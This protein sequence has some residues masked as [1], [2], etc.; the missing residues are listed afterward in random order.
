MAKKLEPSWLDRPSVLWENGNWMKIIPRSTMSREEMA[1][2]LARLA[3]LGG[4]GL[5]ILLR[6]FTVIGLSMLLLVMSSQILQRRK[7][8]ATLTGA[9][10]VRRSKSKRPTSTTGPHQQVAQEEAQVVQQVAQG[11]ATPLGQQKVEP[12]AHQVFTNTAWS[13]FFGVNQENRGA[14][15]G[16]YD[17]M[18]KGAQAHYYEGTGGLDLSQ[19]DS[20]TGLYS[21]IQGN[22][23]YPFPRAEPSSSCSTPTQLGPAMTPQ[24][25][26]GAS[27]VRPF[28][29]EAA[30]QS[31]GPNAYRGAAP[32]VTFGAFGSDGGNTST[33]LTPPTPSGT[34]GS[35]FPTQF[36]Q[37]HHLAEA[38]QALPVS[39]A[40]F[41]PGR[42]N[43]LGNPEVA[44]NRVARPKMCPSQDPRDENTAF[45]ENLYQAPSS[46][47]ANY[48]M[49]PFPVQDVVEARDQFQQFVYGDQTHYKDKFSYGEAAGRFNLI[50]VNQ[51]P[52]GF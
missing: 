11:M 24:T 34:T 22:L 33:F 10:V 35:N 40:C 25:P 45:I 4:G 26:N 41:A 30:N 20:E 32:P 21:G 9:R 2:A 23:L 1:N 46:A 6:S 15:M 7:E 27:F 8:E 14:G 17:A 16:A 52:L 18:T 51:G 12:S 31:V 3:V 19:A 36:Y 42:D 48:S 38:G 39:D 49:M 47:Q 43:L 29:A 50:D 5:A 37:P 44:Q 13:D 28:A